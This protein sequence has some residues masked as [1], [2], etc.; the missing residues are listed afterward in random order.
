MTKDTSLGQALT[1]LEDQSVREVTHTWW[2]KGSRGHIHGMRNCWKASFAQSVSLSLDQVAGKSLCR[3]CFSGNAAIRGQVSTALELV[4]V[5]AL[6]QR[7]KEGLDSDSAEGIS[8][9]IDASV[10][11]LTNLREIE[12]ADHLDSVYSAWQEMSERAQTL[13]AAAKERCGTHRDSV[14]LSVASDLA[15]LELGRAHPG[16]LAYRDV[17]HVPSASGGEIARLGRVRSGAPLLAL[18]YKE[19]RL[20]RLSTNDAQAA[21]DAAEAFVAETASLEDFNQLSGVHVVAQEPADALEAINN[22]WQESVRADIR[23]LVSAWEE[24]TAKNLQAQTLTTLGVPGRDALPY[25]AEADEILSVLRAYDHVETNNAIIGTYPEVIAWWLSGR[26]RRGLEATEV[27]LT[28]EQLATASVLWQP[29][30]K[31]IYAELK[32]VAKAATAL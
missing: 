21:Q 27:A 19:W 12:R 17:F 10:S 18:A 13:L 22:A 32:E 23:A 4:G 24:A 20:T 16:G 31:G 26:V 3:H 15:T 6:L 2:R 1:Y 8:A 11:A 5:E 29:E 7:A 14:L 28:P 9:A 30:S 25:G